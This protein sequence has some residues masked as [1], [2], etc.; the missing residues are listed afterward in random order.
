MCILRYIKSTIEYGIM[1]GTSE[2]LT[3]FCDSDWAR[4]CDSR[5]SIFE[6]CFTLGSRAFSW[7]SKKQPTVALSSIE[8]DIS[9]LGSPSQ[10]G[11]SLE[12][13][14]PKLHGHCQESSVPCLHQAY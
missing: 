8:E 9:T 3:S 10:G 5:K 6:F 2:T 1:Y 11:N 13:R 4:D 14:Q 12:V 7:S